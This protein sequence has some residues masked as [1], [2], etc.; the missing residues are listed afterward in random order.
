VLFIRHGY[1]L[2]NIF[3]G[4]LTHQL[5]RN[6]FAPDPNLTQIG[7]KKAKDLGE[8]LSIFFN[9][10]DKEFKL[11][12]TIYTSRLSR[13][14]ETALGIAKGIKGIK[15][16]E[17]IDKIKT[18]EYINETPIGMFKSIY[19]NIPQEHEKME[20]KV[21]Q[22]MDTTNE[23]EIKIEQYCEDIDNC[24][25]KKPDLEKFKEFFFRLSNQEDINNS[26]LVIFVSHAG[27]MKKFFGEKVN[28]LGMIL[29]EYSKNND[30]NTI[31]IDNI[32][33]QNQTISKNDYKKYIKNSNYGNDEDKKAIR[34]A[35]YIKPFDSIA[36]GLIVLISLGYL[37]V[38][39]FS[40]FAIIKSE[41][42][43]ED[44]INNSDDKEQ[45]KFYKN[46]LNY[47]KKFQNSAL[48]IAITV[49]SIVILLLL[50]FIYIM[51]NKKK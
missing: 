29:V 14:V 22:F 12:K 49:V 36:F 16:I 4:K 23:K 34:R 2:A 3:E 28:N 47:K 46:V 18:I 50:L 37:T 33:L 51:K 15:G 35:G 19:D 39:A 40:L 1:S 42:E 30:K 21:K 5:F 10:Q 31:N 25:I 20:D 27:T 24:K 11:H 41:N 7:Y 45:K 43:L 32:H 6:L 8:K 44:L 17:V 48:P 13:T 38:P 9:K 26:N